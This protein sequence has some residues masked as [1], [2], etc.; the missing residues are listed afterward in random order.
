MNKIVREH[1]P[2]SKLPADLR[3]GIPDSAEVDITV[4]ISEK[5]PSAQRLLAGLNAHREQLEPED[6]VT[7]EDAV[8]RIRALRDEWDER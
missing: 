3:E 8:A 7:A 4:Q 1:Y 2:A 6:C 5:R